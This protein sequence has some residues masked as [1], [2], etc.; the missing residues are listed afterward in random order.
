MTWQLASEE[1]IKKEIKLYR[2]CAKAARWNSTRNGFKWRLQLPRAE[3]WNI[4]PICMMGAK[5]P[6]G[7]KMSEGGRREITAAER[8]VI[9]MARNMNPEWQIFLA[10]STEELG[11]TYGN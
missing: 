7:E 4:A 9:V 8:I 5:W 1:E 6:R 3:E 11:Q 2:A 10:I